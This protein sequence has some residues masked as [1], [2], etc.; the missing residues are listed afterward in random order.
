MNFLRAAARPSEW[1][2]TY[3][4]GT[5]AF[6]NSESLIQSVIDRKARNLARGTDGAARDAGNS[7]TTLDGGLTDLP[8]FQAVKRRQNAKALARLFIEPRQVERLIA[9]SPRPG[10][11]SD[12]RI[13][14]MLERYL[15]AVEYAGA[16]LEWNDAGIVLH[17]VETLDRSKLE[18]WLVHWAGDQAQV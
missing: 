12:A 13:M 6:S 16:T 2:L 18:P 4:D 8:R 11:A 14:E 3:P 10:K 15:K 5:F 1:Y 7:A 9:A 17:T